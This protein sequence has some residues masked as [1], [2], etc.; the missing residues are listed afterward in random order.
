[1]N[2]PEHDNVDFFIGT[3]VEHTPAY[4]MLTLFVVGIQPIDRIRDIVGNR[5]ELL[6]IG[7]AHV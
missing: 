6:E 5:N 1:M 7:R 3:E 2:R 4:G